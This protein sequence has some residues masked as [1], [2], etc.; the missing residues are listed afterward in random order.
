M[1]A[2]IDRLAA[3]SAFAG[4]NPADIRAFVETAAELRIVGP[5]ELIVRAG[6]EPDALW[7]LLDGEVEKLE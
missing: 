4:C 3:A 6:A 1:H 2:T 5:Q 7:F